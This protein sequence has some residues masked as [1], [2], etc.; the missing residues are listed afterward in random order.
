MITAPSQ[1]RQ[2][3]REPWTLDRLLHARAVALGHAIDQSTARTYGSH[4]QSYLTFCK[5]HNFAVEPT[6]DTLSFYTVYMCHHIKPSSVDAYLSGICN[7]LENVFPNVRSIRKHPL[8]TKT[9]AGCKKLLNTPTSRKAPLEISHLST[10]LEHYPPDS[11]DNRLFRALLLSAFFALHRL[12]EVTWPDN[13]E[14]QTWRKVILRSSVTIFDRAYGYTLPAHKADR[15]FEGSSIVI[16]ERL[17]TDGINPFVE[18]KDYL[19][20]RDTLF[21]LQPALW[22]TSDGSIPTRSWFLSRLRACID[23][24][25]VAG[26][27]LRAGGATYFAIIGWPDDRIQA[28]G[29]WSSEAFKI[30]IRKNPVLLHALLHGRRE[31]QRV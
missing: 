7:Q 18:F 8:V 30:Y 5:L 24:P 10:L 12:G 13:K 16:E 14:L 23:N 22:L 1:S 28:L 20:S 19:A 11:H 26:Q 2:P 29:R 21:P 3:L 9:L 15:I 17:D 27:S 4:L 6:V 31:P 25:N